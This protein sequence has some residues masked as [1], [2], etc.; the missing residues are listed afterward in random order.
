MDEK[1][2]LKEPFAKANLP[3]EIEVYTDAGMASARSGDPTSSV[4]ISWSFH[5]FGTEA[6]P[7]YLR[8]SEDNTSRR[9]LDISSTNPQD[10]PLLSDHLWDITAHRRHPARRGS[11]SSISPW[12]KTTNTGT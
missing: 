5:I 1:P 2:T 9:V 6:E 10:G 4:D 7:D 12:R 3:A 8:W 11:H